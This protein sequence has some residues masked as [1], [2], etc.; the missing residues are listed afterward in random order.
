MENSNIR[1]SIHVCNKPS[2]S[3]RRLQNLPPCFRTVRM[4]SVRTQGGW[5]GSLVG[6]PKTLHNQP[7]CVRTLPIRAKKGRGERV[8][9][10]PP[11]YQSGAFNKNTK[12]YHFCISGL[13]EM[14]GHQRGLPAHVGNP[15]RKPMR[16]P[17]ARWANGI[18]MGPR[19]GCRLEII[20]MLWKYSHRLGYPRMWECITI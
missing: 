11:T 7:L 4:R 19:M 2:P 1:A 3:P 20:A 10:Y 6:H 18:R 9:L 15:T 17:L 5:F 14:W 8:A 16:M 12:V 13:R